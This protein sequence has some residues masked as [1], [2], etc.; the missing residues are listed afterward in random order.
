[1]KRYAL[2]TLTWERDNPAAYMPGNYEVT[3]TGPWDAEA[4]EASG[5]G[6]FGRDWRMAVIEGRD[7]SGWT[8]DGY[9]L[10]RLASGGMY[11]REIDL[12]HPI[13]KRVPA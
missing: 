6:S 11:G 5:L 10:P 2:L 13:M 9:V 1:M 3:W 12:S 4:A 8:L 7:N